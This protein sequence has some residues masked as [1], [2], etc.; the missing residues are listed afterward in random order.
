MDI[1]R[2]SHFFNVV[3]AIVAPCCVAI[4]AAWIVVTR[5]QSV[6]HAQSPAQHETKSGSP[7][8]VPR[9]DRAKPAHG[10][11]RSILVALDWFA[12]HQNKEGNW[13]LADY[14][15]HCKDKTCKGVAFPESFSAA[16][17]LALLPFLAAEQTQTKKGPYQK[18]V[19]AGIDWLLHH[20]KADGDLSAGDNLQMY[21]HGLATIA[22]CEDYGLTG[23]KTVGTAAQ[24][25]I[26]FIEA[27]QD[28]KAG[29][30]RFDPTDECDTS[31]FGWQLM[32]LNRARLAGLT[33]K[34]ATLDGAKKWLKS[35]GAE[36]ADLGKFSFRPGGAPDP[37]MS[38]IGLL[39]NQFLG[40][41][42]TDPAITGGVKY[43]M[44]NLPD[45]ARLDREY[46]Y[47]GTQAMHNIADEDWDVW[48]RKLRKI[49]V[50]SQ[51]REGCAAGS[52]NCAENTK[53]TWGGID[54]R[55][56]QT[57]LCC[58]TLEIYYHGYMPLYR[59]SEPQTEPPGDPPKK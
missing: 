18:T 19:A 10:G 21:S 22:L 34:A 38:A 9:A 20:Q 12:R 40:D 50:E 45:S 54:G 47:F 59:L 7:A 13:S 37:A 3:L 30:W 25:A 8:D 17:A 6:A 27:A 5:P 41:G 55:I 58:L 43:L 32:A 44:A 26:N 36:G 35:C 53:H 31:V 57:S 24:K 28:G 46:W 2:R 51:V 15:R 39:S 16:T 14:T 23:D 52:W 4:G 42:H 56:M 11:E 49:L 1:E 48:N 33:V 29:G